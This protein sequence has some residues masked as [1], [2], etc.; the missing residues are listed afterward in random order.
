MPPI[1]DLTDPD[2][3]FRIREAEISALAPLIAAEKDQDRK[4]ELMAMRKSMSEELQRWIFEQFVVMNVKGERRSVYDVFSERGQVPP[5][6]TGDCALPKMLQYAYE[7]GLRPLAFGEFWYGR[8]PRSEVR[9][10]GSF[11]PSCMGKCG[12]LLAYMLKGLDVEPNPMEAYSSV[13]IHEPEILF[14][15]DTIVVVDKPSGLLSVPGKIKAE[16]VLAWLQR[17][18]NH[19]GNGERIYSCHRLDMDTSGVLVFA[20]S[21]EAQTSIMRQFEE[22][23]VSKS[24]VALLAAADMASVNF[25]DGDRQLARHLAKGDRGTVELPLMLDYY[26]RPRQMVDDQDGKG[27]LTEYEVLDE[28]DGGELLVRFVPHTGRTHQLRVHSAHADGLGRPIKGD[29]LYG[30]MSGGRLCLHAEYLRFSHPK[31]GER[32]EFR[33]DPDFT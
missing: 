31:T 33:T 1:F 8:S 20:K 19:A 9:T 2:G 7:N 11:Y 23:E 21:V 10:H 17:R 13:L 22:R 14:E 32:M 15:D 5:G 29:R 4:A 3:Y 24:Y 26:D 30:D 27:A 25:S 12:P 16:S 18:A 6:G 28:M